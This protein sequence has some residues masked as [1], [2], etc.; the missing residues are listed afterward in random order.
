MRKLRV[1]RGR[2]RRV[3]D[4]YLWIFADQV[5][6]PLK[7]FQ[8]GQIVRV[9]TRSGRFLGIGTVNPHS[10]IACRLLCRREM[11]IGI[12]FFVERCRKSQELRRR[13]LPG[14]AAVREVFSESDGLPGLIVDRYGDILVF[15]VTTAGM[16]GL[17]P[18]IIEA[19]NEVYQPAGIYERSDASVRKLEG[20]GPATGVVSGKVPEKPFPVKFAGVYLYVNV[21]DGQ[22]TGLYLDQRL[23]LLNLTRF[24][25]G[26]RV[27]DAFCYV[28]AW[29]I[30]AAKSGGARKVTFLD[31]SAGALEAVQKAAGRARVADISE[32]LHGD[33]FELFKKMAV[34]K[35]KFDVIFLDPPSFIRSRSRF[36]E[37]YRGYFDLNQ[38]AL[39]LLESGGILVTC[40][41]S[42]HVRSDSFFEMLNAVLRRS[43]RNGRILYVGGQAPDHPVLPQM[44]ETNYL[45]CVA[46]QIS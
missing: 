34:E 3:L 37:G 20:L 15:S 11:E 44:P 43:E 9:T 33:A 18:M 32:I 31:S 1:K 46:L 16:D 19:L 14:E 24:T 4:G 26:A 23:N 13:I 29:G 41:C 5:D 42:H 30:S 36:K 10:L 40:S 8:P 27:L 35:R 22:K 39:V 25:T 45:K 28:G 21:R 12:D 6:D 7:D 2:E 38:K 17:K